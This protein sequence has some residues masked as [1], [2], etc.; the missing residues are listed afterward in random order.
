MAEEERSKLLN[1]L[2]RQ[3]ALGLPKF[4]PSQSNPLSVDPSC[5]NSLDGFFL[6]EARQLL[7]LGVQ[8]RDPATFLLHQAAN[9]EVL[10]G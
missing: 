5:D 9:V 3:E 8:D 4:K 7:A 10:P 1:L 2:Q 6:H